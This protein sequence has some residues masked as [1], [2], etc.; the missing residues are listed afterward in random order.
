MTVNEK[1]SCIAQF[2]QFSMVFFLSSS[3][4]WCLN[5]Y[6]AFFYTQQFRFPYRR[7]FFPSFRRH[8]FSLLHTHFNDKTFL[9][10]LNHWF[11]Y[12]FHVIFFIKYQ[13]NSS[14]IHK[15]MVFDGKGAKNN[16]QCFYVSAFDLQFDICRMH[17]KIRCYRIILKN[18][19][20]YLANCWKIAWVL[21]TSFVA[22]FNGRHISGK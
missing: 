21:F 11:L 3:L 16:I 19:Y 20:S 4:F 7:W 8:S 18:D 9:F 15:I 14:K 2:I 6:A 5:F 17:H 12:F 10:V 22:L 1:S 13:I